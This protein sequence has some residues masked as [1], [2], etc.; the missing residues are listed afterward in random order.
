MRAE[1]FSSKERR[2][3]VGKK[4]CSQEVLKERENTGKKTGSILQL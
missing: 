3:V 4:I 1:A 2:C